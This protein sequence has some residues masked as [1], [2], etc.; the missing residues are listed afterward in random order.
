MLVV[1]DRLSNVR[2]KTTRIATNVIKAGDQAETLFLVGSDNGSNKDP[3]FYT[4]FQ[5]FFQPKTPRIP[6]PRPAVVL[7]SPSFDVPNLQ[8]PF[9]TAPAAFSSHSGESNNSDNVFQWLF[10]ISF[11]LPKVNFKPSSSP[12][13]FHLGFHL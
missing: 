9:S 4:G 13:F 10:H 7:F 8:R 2:E 5:G 12:F 6:S 1:N 3:L 11:S